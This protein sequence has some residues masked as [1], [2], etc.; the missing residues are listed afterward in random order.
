MVVQNPMVVDALIVH[1]VTKVP[2]HS[3]LAV[4]MVME[5]KKVT[6]GLEMTGAGVEPRSRTKMARRRRLDRV[7][8]SLARILVK[9]VWDGILVLLVIVIRSSMT[10]LVI[11]AKLKVKIFITQR[12]SVGSQRA[13]TLHR[14]P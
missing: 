12:I 4:P 2:A 1:I 14:A 11:F 6:R 8:T 3:V 10:N 13:D 9:N 5:L 7:S